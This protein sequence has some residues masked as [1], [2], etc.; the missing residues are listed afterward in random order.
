[1]SQIADAGLSQDA[2]EF[3]PGSQLCYRVEV[4]PEGPISASYV[5][6]CI[7]L[8]LPKDAIARW[9]RPEEVSIEAEQRLDGGRSL[10]I[11]VEKDFA[12]LTPRDG[13]DNE[14]DLFP[15]PARAES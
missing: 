4:V 9:Q 5:G 8:R 15:N 1:M 11:L 3:G 2:V 14:A 12:C 10:K 13:E 6:D 7:S